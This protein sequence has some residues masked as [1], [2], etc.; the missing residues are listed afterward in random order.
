MVLGWMNFLFFCELVLSILLDITSP[1]V[2]RWST[3]CHPGVIECSGNPTPWCTLCVSP[4]VGR[5]QIVDSKATS[6]KR[7]WFRTQSVGSPCTARHLTQRD[8]ILNQAEGSQNISARNLTVLGIHSVFLLHAEH[9]LDSCSCP[10]LGHAVGSLYTSYF[11]AAT[12][13]FP[14]QSLPGTPDSECQQDRPWVHS[15]VCR[16]WSCKHISC[17]QSYFRRTVWYQEPVPFP[18]RSITKAQCRE[19]RKPTKPV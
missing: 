9:H 7:K 19:E 5:E 11:L 1:L 18:L 8:L 15:P 16:D 6:L 17:I 4:M 13:I 14:V 12:T 10:T 3:I 2:C